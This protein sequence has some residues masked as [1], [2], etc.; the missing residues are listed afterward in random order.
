VEF[1]NNSQIFRPEVTVIFR[2][3]SLPGNTERL[4]GESAA[5]KVNWGEAGGTGGWGTNQLPASLSR[6]DGQ[7]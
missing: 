5:N 1:G 7:A 4:A 6:I 3:S 2:A